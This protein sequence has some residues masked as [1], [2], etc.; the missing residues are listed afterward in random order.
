VT[1]PAYE[2]APE[3]AREAPLT[4]AAIGISR[5]RLFRDGQGV[6]TLAAGYGCPLS[7]RFCINAVCRDPAFRPKR[8]TVSELY[9]RLRIDDLYF[10]A[11]N[12]GI[13]FGGGEPLLQAPFLRAFID[14]VR[15]QGKNWRFSVETSLAVPEDAVRMLFDGTEPSVSEWLVDAKDLNPAIY[16]AYA[17]FTPDRTLGNLR[18]LASV[19]PELVTVRLPKIPGFNSD[20]D[21]DRSEETLRRM[22]FTRFDR[23]DYI[24]PKGK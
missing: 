11:T 6:T 9:D 15:E 20:E 1:A 3:T 21:R 2:N 18:L 16:E 24:L 22:G 10:E 8:Y 13:T 5:H 14:Y 7:C 4:F 23:F 19:C 17:D 12:G